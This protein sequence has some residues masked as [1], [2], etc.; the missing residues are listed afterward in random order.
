M[1]DRD[2]RGTAHDRSREPTDRPEFHRGLARLAGRRAAA[3]WS[4]G[5]GWAGRGCTGTRADV[6]AAATRRP[7]QGCD[8]TGCHRRSGAPGEWRHHARRTRAARGDHGT[9]GGADRSGPVRGEDRGRHRRR[10]RHR[11]RH[12]VPGRPRGRPRDRRRRLAGAPRR[13]R[14]ASSPDAD[15]VAVSADITDDDGVA[16]IVAAA[17]DRIDG[18]ANIAGIMDD[19]TPLARGDRQGLGPRVR[20]STSTAPSSSCAP[21]SRRC[22]TA[23]DGSIVNIASEAALRGSAAGLA[24]TA[25]KHAVVGITKSSALHVRRRRGIRV[26][27]VAPGPTITNIEATF[28]SPLGAERVQSAMRHHSDR[29]RAGAAR[30]VDHV[31]AQRRWDERHRCDPAVGRWLVHPV[32][33]TRAESRRRR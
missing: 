29:R 5:T 12:G 18:L 6:P 4:A 10:F 28:D 17:G 25:S 9:M 27:A 16:A 11:P 15:I 33:L 31:P 21:S 20:A 8:D 26:N 1:R 22:S 24:Y 23:G 14:S 32:A 7:E 2:P 3:R 13:V 19:M 30:R